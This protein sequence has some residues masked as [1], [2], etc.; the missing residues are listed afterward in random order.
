M[1]TVA[2]HLAEI[3]IAERP[4]ED[5]ILAV[6]E[7]GQGA[8]HFTA[9]SLADRDPARAHALYV[10]SG[11]F[12][13][14]SVST[15]AGRS[16][17]NVSRV[18]WL[19]FDAD[20]ADWLQF[21]NDR[22][23]DG[24]A[25]R[26]RLYAELRALDDG[27][28]MAHVE[29]QRADLEEAFAKVGIPIHRLDYTGYG[30][31]AYVY[32]DEDDQARV[33]DA[34]EAHRMLIRAV[35]DVAKPIRL[36]DPQVSDA[37]TRITRLPGSVNR[38][39]PIERV[40]RTLIFPGGSIH[41]GER[42]KTVRPAATFVPRDGEGLSAEAVDA[43]IAAIS[44]SWT[45]GQKHAMGLAVGGI[46][47]KAG[48]PESQAVAIVERLAA[49]DDMPRDRMKA[50]ARSYDRVRSGLSV[51]GF[52][53]LRELV[54]PDV[55][56]TID[57]VL[58][59]FRRESGV[60]RT[61]APS[62]RK[63]TDDLPQAER[64]ERFVERQITPP[65]DTVYYGWFGRYR[66][67]MAPTT[68]APDQYHLTT[69]LVFAGAMVG[70]RIGA[71]YASNNLYPNLYAALIGRSNS[72]RKDTAINRA[73]MLPRCATSYD[74][75][76]VGPGFA[77]N[78]DVSSGEG[79]IKYLS[80]HP[81]TLMTIKELSALLKNAH[82]KGTG[83]I[84]D[85]LIEAWDTPLTLENNA[86]LSGVQAR[87]PCLSII[88]ATQPGRIARDMTSEEIESGF[89]N[90]WLFVFGAAKERMARPPKVNQRAAYEL[91]LE[92]YE[93]VHH[94]ADGTMIHLGGD[95]VAR[96]DQWYDDAIESMNQADDEDDA[97]MRGRHAPIIQ[98]IALL[99]AVSD[100][101]PT[102]DLRHLEPAITF[103][104]WTWTCVKGVL[105]EWGASSDIQLEEKILSS[106]KKR[107]SM[108]RRDLQRLCS[109]RRWSAKDFAMVMRAMFENET[110][111]VDQATGLVGINAE[112]S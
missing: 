47:A 74:Q 103:V 11:V 28:L 53:S 33:A 34:K 89:A 44:P 90:R 35:N 13:Q 109:G 26:A 6:I 60:G 65:P 85:R 104:E 12:R 62:P 88:A 98:K 99:F 82:R 72:T 56:H 100:R 9:R 8:R 64:V 54:P 108:K 49:G 94:Y 92:L 16:Q 41:L 30:L 2:E 107:G 95:A 4:D 110:L 7:P 55:L 80:E 57:G 75:R 58:T 77:V 67:L 21:P 36:V 101:S 25:E 79:L 27:E 39:G 84:I 24:K 69:S 15:Y 102:I 105:R 37:G 93:S 81:N 23:E 10:A 91:Y 20:L 29:R 42:P 46:F 52:H 106:L 111:I 63:R 87:N 70:R 14:G 43:L 59:A 83:T 112:E 17:D 48:V 78:S 76:L 96:W 1:G 38:K 50:V 71:D 19:P 31:C 86:K 61:L 3:G 18:L 40:V 32:L 73:M 5:A 51:R 22:T 66:E 97:D 45:L 68:E